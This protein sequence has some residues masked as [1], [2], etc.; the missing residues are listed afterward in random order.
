[1]LA[2]GAWYVNR[3]L[4]SQ[5]DRIPDP[6]ATLS[7]RP[8]TP[9]VGTARKAKNILVI[10]TDRR[11]DEPTTGE[12]ATAPTWL[13]GEQRSDTLM[14]LHVSGDREN[15]SGISIPRDAWVDIPGH[16]PAKVNAAFSYGGPSLA[17]Q[18]VEKLTGVRIDHLAVIDWD[19]FRGVIDSLGAIDVEVAETV[20][21]SARD[22]T[23]EA[24]RHHLDGE[25]ALLFVRQ[26]YGLPR[27]DLDRVRRQQ[28][29]MRAVMDKV[30]DRKLW[31]DPLG[32]YRLLDAVTSNLSLDEHWSL[33]RV[34]RLAGQ[35][36]KVDRDRFFFTTVPVKG[37]G[38]VGDQSVVFLD[39]QAGARLWKAVREDRVPAWFAKRPDADLPQGAIA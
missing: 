30:L 3:K 28:L 16:G 24:G 9:D 34:R 5:V 2:G 12:N 32:S 20:H 19:G 1:M 18:T 10:G 6:F 13:P 23:W 14:L 37:T 33:S 22:K 38:Y 29:V 17:V 25:E 27:G 21:D 4:T 11:S 35:V 36:A 8:V 26:R 31:S 15:V 7:N 39:H